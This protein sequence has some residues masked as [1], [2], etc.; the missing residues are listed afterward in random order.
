MSMGDGPRATR[1]S[2]DAIRRR[3]IE[4]RIA[5]DRASAE[6][7]WT[8]RLKGRRKAAERSRLR[9]RIDE[10]PS[11]VRRLRE[12]PIAA[13]LVATV[14]GIAMVAT[15]LAVTG[16]DTQRS[17]PSQAIASLDQA[18]SS[19]SDR[20]P[21]GRMPRGDRAGTQAP[22]EPVAPAGTTTVARQDPRLRATTGALPATIAES[23][24]MSSQTVAAA[25][26]L[27]LPQEEQETAAGDGSDTDL[28]TTTGSI[29]RATAPDPL[30][31][32]QIADGL[33]QQAETL[34]PNGEAGTG[35]ADAR[36]S[37]TPVLDQASAASRPADT[38][39]VDASVNGN[40]NASVNMRQK[41]DN[42]AAVV[43]VLS[44][45]QTVVVVGCDQWCEVTAGGKAGYVFKSFIDKAG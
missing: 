1:P 20:S 33:E 29:T 45:G 25:L 15:V 10:R 13:F 14:A 9:S 41:P 7:G 34:A 37:T 44:K 26:A 22:L 40:V 43:A 18:R 31:A 35:E 17:T 12:R 11:L 39:R 3:L 30:P 24:S 19:V 8:T 36:G 42:E 16:I 4:R 28:L 32:S 38:A 5:H 6:G 23:P 21:Y 2:E 27:R